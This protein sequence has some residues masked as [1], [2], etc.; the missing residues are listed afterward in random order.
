MHGASSGRRFGRARF[1]AI[2]VPYIV[3]SASASAPPPDLGALHL[4]HAHG[5]TAGVRFVA[6]RITRPRVGPP[7]VVPVGNLILTLEGPGRRE[8]TP[9]GGALDLLPGEYAYTLTNEVLGTLPAGRYRFVVRAL[10]SAG[11]ATVTRRSRT[12]RIG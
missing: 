9:P 6:G 4:I 3:V 11:G 10:G 8:L 1:G 5:R 2:S 12:F 7:S